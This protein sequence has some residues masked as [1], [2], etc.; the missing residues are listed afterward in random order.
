MAVHDF[1]THCC[2]LYF[3]RKKER[4][5]ASS[6]GG[7]LFTKWGGLV[8]SSLTCDLNGEEDSQ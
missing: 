1:Y 4:R 7:S 2:Y 5:K 6:S 3:S 8:D